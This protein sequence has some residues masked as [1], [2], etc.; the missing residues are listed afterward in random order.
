MEK[1][2]VIVYWRKF[3]IDLLVGTFISVVLLGIAGFTFGM[4][5]ASMYAIFYI[6]P[7]EWSKIIEWIIIILAT[8]WLGAL[9]VFHG[10]VASFI[11]VVSKKLSEMVLGL[12]DLFDILVSEVMFSYIGTN[13]KIPKKELAEKFDNVG[14]KFLEDLKLKKGIFN[15]IYRI[16]FGV[17]LKV[18][19][20]IFLDDVVE[21]LRNKKSDHLGK[22]DIESAIRRVGVEFVVSSI[23]DNLIILHVVNGVLMLITFS[24]PFLYF[25]FF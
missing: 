14:K 12:H 25:W 1:S 10:L 2:A 13:E 22:A 23:K 24:I 18:L 21:E 7:L 19:K 16:I 8:F 20:F 11:R 4:T 17:I 9:G 6:I 15:F 5:S 3:F